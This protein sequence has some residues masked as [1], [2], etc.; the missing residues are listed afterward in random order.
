MPIDGQNEQ[1]EVITSLVE[2]TSDENQ[3]HGN[4][5]GESTPTEV[6]TTGEQDTSAAPVTAQ[7]DDEL[8]EKYR[9][10]TAR[11]IAEM[12]LEAEKK[13][14]QQGAERAEAIRRAQELEQ[15]TRQYE[16]YFS[17][18]QGP[19]DPLQVL[20]QKWNDSPKEAIQSAFKFFQEERQQAF[21]QQQL[22][23]QAR[24]TAARYEQLKS[25]DPELPELE[26]EMIRL[27]HELADFVP[28]DKRNS[29][30]VLD[31]LYQMARARK[32]DGIVNKKVEAAL[33][34]LKNK[35]DEKKEVFSESGKSAGET[36]VNP[37]DMSLEQL[38]AI[39][40]VKQ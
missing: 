10:K 29:P 21:R 11:Q 39:L 32:I 5:P 19:S 12:H 1:E 16:S 34:K 27:S 38:R 2:A 20:E 40:P 36:Q 33:A 23:A 37:E 31:A 13:I 14:S 28:Q 22:E 15:R 9:G 24:A 18:Q 30:Q 17:Q 3:D 7:V 4:E 25:E 26:P 35:R 8:P 6:V